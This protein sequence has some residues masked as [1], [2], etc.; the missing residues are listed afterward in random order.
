MAGCS[1]LKDITLPA[2]LTSFQ[3]D[4]S[5]CYAG[6]FY[7]TDYKK[8]ENDKPILNPDGTPIYIYTP[9]GAIYYK[10]YKA[11]AD[12]LLANSTNTDLKNRISFTSAM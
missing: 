3:D 8:D 2:G 10:N 4:L 6:Y 7:A 1:S 9:D 11:A 5:R 12:A